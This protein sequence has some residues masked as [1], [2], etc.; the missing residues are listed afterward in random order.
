LF[1]SSLLTS[2]GNFSSPFFVGKVVL[3]A[4][5][6]LNVEVIVIVRDDVTRQWYTQNNFWFIAILFWNRNWKSSRHSK[7][8]ISY[9][10]NTVN[11][12]SLLR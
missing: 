12:K 6:Y 2:S 8:I 3:T 10:W 11:W 7:K 1:F 9:F 5:L 4:T